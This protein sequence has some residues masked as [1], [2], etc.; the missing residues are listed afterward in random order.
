MRVYLDHNATTPLR[1]EARTAMLAA[2]DLAGNPSSVH[3]EGRAA[4]MLIEKAR[5][6]VAGLAR[7]DV[8]EVIFTS[9]ATE[10]VAGVV[11]DATQVCGAVI[12]HEAVRV[13]C[14][15]EGMR[16]LGVDANGHLDLSGVADGALAGAVLFVQ[17]ANSETGV[18]Q[19]NR[20]E[21]ELER[22]G[23]TASDVFRDAVQ[24]AGKVAD[25]GRWRAGQGPH[26]FM[27]LSAHKLGGPKGVGALIAGPDYNPGRMSAML[28]GGGQESGRRAGT[29]NVIGIAGFGAACEAAARDL[30]DGVWERVAGLR[31]VLEKALEAGS[32]KTI[33]V[34]KHVERLPNTSCFITPGWRGDMQ[35]MQMD[36]A[37]FAISAGS[38]CSSGKVATS[39]VLTA[40]GFDDAQAAC[41]VRVSLGADTTEEH[42][43]R[44]ADAWTAKLKKHEARA[45]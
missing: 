10:A 43:L 4:K 5:A 32:K 24:A 13:W 22:V 14:E 29:E 19:P 41:A 11:H 17:R 44:F 31:N 35:V 3:A 6:Q 25:L 38:A 34:G 20:L 39:R 23:I 18:L 42:V 36:L 12:E 37:G 1:P 40:M 28:R 15:D 33:F 45:A 27:A 21:G 7:C 9:G 16:L 8:S 26:A 2:M 30:S